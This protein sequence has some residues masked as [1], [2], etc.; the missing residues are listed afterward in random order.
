MARGLRLLY[1]VRD[2]FCG[3]SGGGRLVFETAMNKDAKI[4]QASFSAE[5]DDLEGPRG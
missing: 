3:A 5:S 2:V 4:M 1:G